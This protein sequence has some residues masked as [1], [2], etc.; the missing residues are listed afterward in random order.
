M[1]SF[2]SQ[3]DTG[4]FTEGYGDKEKR[5][6]SNGQNQFKHSNQIKSDL[7]VFYL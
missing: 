7:N 5:C 1:C 4:T 6:R 3:P 2:S